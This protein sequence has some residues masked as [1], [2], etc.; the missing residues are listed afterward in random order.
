MLA[1]ALSAIASA[2]STQALD[3]IRIRLLSRK[4][5]ITS[6]L[7]SLKE[8]PID[9][10]KEIGA[11]ANK[12]RVAVEQALN[13]ARD[14]L[15]AAAAISAL[16]PT[17]P[18][19]RQPCGA[20]H[21][22][23][24]VM[25]Q[26][27]QS[28]IRMGFGVAKGPDVETDYYNFEALNF[29]PDHPARDMQDT[30]YVAGNKLLRTHTTPVQVRVLEAQQPPI[31]VI[32]P[33]KTYRNETVSARSHCIFHQ[34]DGFLVDEGVTMADLKGAIYAFCRDF[35]GDD[36]RLKF[37]TSFFP[38][39]EPSAEVD[40]SCFLC[41]GKGCPLCKQ[42]GWLEILGCGM[43]D[44][45]VLRN[46]GCDPE[47]YSGYAFGI[48]VERIAMLKYGITDIRL[49]YENDVRFIRQFK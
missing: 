45:N 29:P 25:D 41:K 21:P 14:R 23:T 22:I 36:V 15:L 20:L 27:C 10:R 19:I 6:I 1:E 11:A 44:P 31:K 7:K 13:E 18:G 2:S 32:M 48:G 38:F 39:T 35:F 16:D 47:K 4:G 3:E 30:F 34:V 12:A 33:G 46:V 24:L 43:I 26:L 17:L 9:Q 8:L 42:Y 5:D 37:R 28:F 40:I 49:F